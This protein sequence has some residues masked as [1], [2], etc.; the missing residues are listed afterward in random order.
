MSLPDNDEQIQ[1]A[2]ED[3]LQKFR[4]IASGKGL[5]HRY[6]F[7]NYGYYKDD[8]LAS[9]GKNSVQKMWEVSKRY[10]PNG[11]FQKAMPGGFK[12]PRVS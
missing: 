2:V 12:L 9:Y 10:D 7:T 6:I 11:L 3:L 4:N 5:L 1:S 8:V